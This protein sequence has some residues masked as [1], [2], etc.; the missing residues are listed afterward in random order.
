MKHLS[1]FILICCLL[2]CGQTKNKPSEKPTIETERKVIEPWSDTYKE[3]FIHNCKIGFGEVD[4]NYEAKVDIFCKC[5]L[6]EVM[7]S[8]NSSSEWIKVEKKMTEDDFMQMAL[9]CSGA[10]E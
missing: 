5:C 10:L 2:A 1:L 3:T 9:P 6:N 7:S 8:S 4:I